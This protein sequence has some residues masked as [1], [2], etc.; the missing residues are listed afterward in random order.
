[1]SVHNEREFIELAIRSLLPIADE[2]VIADG[3]YKLFPCKCNISKDGTWQIVKQWMRRSRKITYFQC[4]D[5]PT[6]CEKRNRLLRRVKSGSWALTIDGD[7]ILTG[8]VDALRINLATTSANCLDIPVIEKRADDLDQ[9]HWAD[10]QPRLWR[11][12]E[13]DHY[14][15]FHWNL[16]RRDGTAIKPEGRLTA[17]N[18]INLSHLR[19]SE[20]LKVRAEYDRIMGERK[21]RES[22]E[23]PPQPISA[24]DAKCTVV[25]GK[26]YLRDFKRRAPACVKPLMVIMSVRRIP[27]VLKAFRKLTFIDKVWFCNYTPA[28]VS[29]EI[30]RY[31]DEHGDK[32]THIIVTS[33]DVAP[34]AANIRR[35]V[36]DVREYDLPCVAGYCN[37][38]HLDRQDEHGGVCSACVDG[39][40]HTHANVTFDPV[41]VE[42]RSFSREC[43]NFVTMEWARKHSGIHRVWFQGMACGLVSMSTHKHVPFR[44]WDPQAKGGLMQDLAFAVDCAEKG[45]LQFVDFRVGMRHYGTHHGKLLVGKEPPRVHFEAAKQP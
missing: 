31:L 27:E 1:M 6:Q 17:I 42:T 33:D 45:I 37:L 9:V 28:Q 4:K 3:A 34:T 40:P 12:Q 10:G 11:Y 30:N 2:I 36:R 21:W 7:E 14:E 20:K 32:Y 39:R 23:E 22:D 43:Y 13:G 16:R 29:G 44:S 35:L 15:T 38:C 41:D 5:R 19:Q 18:I 26:R 24:S 25:A 8:H